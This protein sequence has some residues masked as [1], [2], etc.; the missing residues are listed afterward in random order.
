[1]HTHQQQ[2]TDNGEQQRQ[3]VF[4]S[5]SED[6]F[7]RF[8]RSSL[9]IFKVAGGLYYNQRCCMNASYLNIYVFL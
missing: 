8:H 3:G 4:A 5:K 2:H 6:K 7:E 1:L 9:A